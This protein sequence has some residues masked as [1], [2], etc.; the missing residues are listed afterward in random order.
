MLPIKAYEPIVEIRDRTSR[1]LFV[2]VHFTVETGEAERIAVDWASKGG[3]GGTS[4]K[5]KSKEFFIEG[6]YL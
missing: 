2:E 5:F 3:A 1:S 6:L 4:C